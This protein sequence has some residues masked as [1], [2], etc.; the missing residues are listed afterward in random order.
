MPPSPD[1]EMWRTNIANPTTAISFGKQLEDFEEIVLEVILT[2]PLLNKLDV[3]AGFGV[4]EVWI[5]KDGSF[6][7]YAVDRNTGGYAQAERSTRLPGLDFAMSARYAV[8]P[9]APQALREF[10]AELRGRVS[11]SQRRHERA[12]EPPLSFL[13]DGVTTTAP[14]FSTRT[15]RF[16]WRGDAARPFCGA[17]SREAGGLRRS[18]STARLQVRDHE[19]LGRALSNDEDRRN[20]ITSSSASAR[21]ARRSRRPSRTRRQRSRRS[22]AR[23]S[24]RCSCGLPGPRRRARSSG[25]H[26]RPAS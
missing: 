10:E 15:T 1:H 8:R 19:Q 12:R 21:S 11:P 7:I 3:Y 26:R 6:R 14:T 25:S 2:S 20:W 24:A 18:T 23:R 16:R 5:F 13:P 4:A 9:D 22:P 17:P